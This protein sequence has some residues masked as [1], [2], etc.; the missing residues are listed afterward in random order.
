MI[1]YYKM[2]AGVIKKHYLC[3]RKGNKNSYTDD[4][5]ESTSW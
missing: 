4:N 5:N 1:K 3:V 2:L